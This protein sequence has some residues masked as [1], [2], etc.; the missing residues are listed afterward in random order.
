MFKVG[1]KIKI[2]DSGLTNPQ[3]FDLEGEVVEIISDNTVWIV[4]PNHPWIGDPSYPPLY[5]W[6]F[7]H[8]SERMALVGGSTATNKTRQEKPCQVCGRNNDVG[9]SICWMCGHKPF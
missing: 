7:L 6:K 5:K 4:L 1:D 9:V 8:A 3:F 2:L